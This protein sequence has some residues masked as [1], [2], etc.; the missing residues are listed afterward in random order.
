MY[1]IVSIHLVIYLALSISLFFFI[2]DSAQCFASSEIIRQ[3]EQINREQDEQLR[4]L[5]QKH[6]N[7]QDREPS[8]IEINQSAPTVQRSEAGSCVQIDSIVFVGATLLSES[9][10]AGLSEIGRAHV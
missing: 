2:N 10:K 3:Q 8:Q 1:K 5:K 4:K 9:D 7:A 6:E